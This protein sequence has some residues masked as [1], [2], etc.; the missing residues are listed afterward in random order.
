MKEMLFLL[1]IGLV[2]WPFLFTIGFYANGGDEKDLQ[3]KLQLLRSDDSIFFRVCGFVMWIFF[4]KKNRWIISF[5]SLIFLI[6]LKF[7]DI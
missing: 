3:K 7:G 5:S 2:S 1:M 6:I 4:D